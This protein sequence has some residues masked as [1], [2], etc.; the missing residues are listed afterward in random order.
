M[1]KYS[2][3]FIALIFCGLMISCASSPEKKDLQGGKKASKP[4]SEEYAEAKLLREKIQDHDLDQF[5]PEEYENGEKEYE[6]G[7]QY[8]NKNNS[9]SKKAFEEAKRLY[10]RVIEKGYP[11]YAKGL[12]I[13][14]G[15]IKDEADDIKA[16]VAMKKE[17]AEALEAYE[18]GLKEQEAGNHEKAVSLLEKA[19]S[20]F[21]EVRKQTL[22]KREKAEKSIETSKSELKQLEQKVEAAGL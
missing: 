11:S 5:A 22:V 6:E 17:Y 9:K 10:N 15:E 1:K 18:Q 2:F 14:V 20:L 13:E 12:V 19:K 16:S 3:L 21:E 7:E 4:P 8:Y